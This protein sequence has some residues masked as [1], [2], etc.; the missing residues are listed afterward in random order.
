MR[1]WVYT[2]LYVYE[3]FYIYRKSRPLKINISTED[4]GISEDFHEDFESE[5][6]GVS[7]KTWYSC[8]EYEAWRLSFS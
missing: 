2:G 5:E 3:E 8:E 1:L 6:I 4:F 7:V